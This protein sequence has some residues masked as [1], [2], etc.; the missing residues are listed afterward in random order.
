MAFLKLFLCACGAYLLGSLNFGIII[1]KL[2]TGKDLRSYGS[3]NAGSTNAYRVL[4]ARALFVVLGDALKGVIAVYL[5][6]YLFGDY[7]RICAFMFVIFGHVYPIFYGFKGGKGILTTCAMLAVFDWRIACIL[8]AI[9]LVIFAISHF[10]SL[11]SVIAVSL[12]P[13]CTYLFY[14]GKLYFTVCTLFMAFWIVVLHKENIGRLV[15]GTE[16]KIFFKKRTQ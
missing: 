13:L 16:K 9:F 8:F 6:W 10:V 12:M 4:G 2:F 5:G 7:G 11:G 1:T 14:P 3:G 15:L